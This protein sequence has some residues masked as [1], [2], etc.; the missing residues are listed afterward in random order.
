LASV[1]RSQSARR[2]LFAREGNSAEFDL[3]AKSF[4][5]LMRM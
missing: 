1:F 3:I 4:A 5:N 2:Q